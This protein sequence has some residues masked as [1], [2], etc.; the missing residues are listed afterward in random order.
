MTCGT[1]LCAP[2]SGLL[3]WLVEYGV[4][5]FA[6][7]IFVLALAV[8]P[9]S[10]HNKGPGAAGLCAYLEAGLLCWIISF[11]TV[12]SLSDRR[13]GIVVVLLVALLHYFK[14][15]YGTFPARVS[16]HAK[17]QLA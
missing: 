16:Y 1:F 4:F 9:F 11:V 3:L 2:E 15:V 5:V 12:Y 14:Y 17:P 10:G 7:I 6:A 8:N 13:I